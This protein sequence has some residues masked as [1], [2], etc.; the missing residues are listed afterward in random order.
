LITAS[1]VGGGFFLYHVRTVIIGLVLF[2]A[3]LAL[4][5][6]SGNRHVRGRL[7]GS[8]LAFA[9]YALAHSLLNYADLTA[10]FRQQI[11]TFAPL[12]LAW[13]VISGIVAIV[14]NP[15][16]GDRTPDRFP[17][18]VQ[19]ALA[20]ALFAIAATI[21]LQ[22]KIVA[23]TAVSA[24]VI[25]FA[26]QDTLGNLFAGLA[27]Q[28]EKPFRVGHWVHI[29][30]KDGMVHEITWRA[31]KIRT[32]AGN[33]VIVPNS[34]L[35]KEPITNYS[36]PFLPT[37][38][39]VEVGASYNDPP[40]E[41]QA[42]I[43]EALEHEP[44]IARQPQP[45]V[46][47][48]NFADSAITYRAR[49]WI[50]DYAADERTTTRVRLLI[51]HTFRRRGF[52]IPYP[53]AWRLERGDDPHT[54][55]I[56]ETAAAQALDAVEIFAA[57]NVEDREQLR[58]S[59]APVHY[60][61][62][63]TI[64]RQGEAGTSMFVVVTG[65]AKVTLEPSGQEVFRFHGQGFFGEM[66][67]LTGEPR[68][69]TVTAVTACDLL[70]ITADAFRRFVLAR[71]ASVEAIGMATAQRAT[72]LTRLRNAGAASDRPV[73]PPASLVSRIRRFLRI[74]SIILVTS[75]A[76]AASPAS[77]GE[78]GLQITNDGR[79]TVVAV[80]SKT[81][82]TLDGALDEP[83]WTAAEP[84]GGFVQAE[85][86]EGQPAT[87]TTEVRLV[88]DS[89]ALYLGVRCNDA[90]G[91]RTIIN[92]IRKDFSAGEQDSFEVI[93][94]TFADRRNGFVFVVN[95]VGGKSDTQIAN[96]GRDV[97][98]SWDAVWFVVTRVD[99]TGW[100]AEIRIPFKTLRFEPGVDRV[101][102]VNFS[103]RI[104]R[105]N[106]VDFW[107]PVPRV[108]NLYRASLGGTMSG[109]PNANPGRNLRLKPWVSGDATRAVSGKEFDND[110]HAGIDLKY[111]VTPSL[112]L[113]VTAR[114][115]FAQAEADEQQ[116]NLTQF[117]LFYPEKREFFLENSGM[118]YFGDIPRESRL[119][120]ARFA[121]PEEEILLFFSRRI[122]LTNTGDPIPIAAGGRLTGRVGRTGLGLMTIQT[123]SDDGRD[124]DNYTVLRG[125]R[126][127]LRN[128]DIGGIFLSRQ[129]TGDGGRNQVAG[130]DANFR[131]INALSLNGFL[132]QS[133]TPGKSS[134]QVA[135]K[136]AITWN[137]NTLHTQYSLLSI[138]DNFRD[139]IGFIKR[140]GIRKHFVDF[141]IR[142]RP[143]WWR[144]YGIRELHPHTRYNIYTDQS[145]QKVS[146]T[147]HVA[148][149]T[150]FERGGYLEAQWNPRFER[151]TTPFR[152][153]PD[154]SFPVGSYSWNEFAVELET[155][156]S[157]K[158]SGSALVTGG[159]FWSGTQRSAKL[160]VVYRPSYHLT[161]DTALQRNDISLPAPMHDFT[162]NLIASR[163]GYAF[164]TRT[165]LDTLLQYNTDLKQ[166]SA[167]VRF[168]LIHRPLSDLFIVY[169]EQQLTDSPVPVSSGRGLIVKYTHMVAF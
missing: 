113:D 101:W 105:K 93:L 41:V 88:F 36:E 35:S 63:E 25:G 46:V 62:G 84:A 117:S 114:P 166:F 153:R 4:R 11:V 160:G 131:F 47:I 165:F 91:G 80:E 43:L 39:E 96:E 28:I 94:D 58:R 61:E 167:N 103:R 115:D 138:G 45:D 70:E 54:R 74:G 17:N 50:D 16:R 33:L 157:Q 168:D 73:E 107:S 72:E 169:N 29:A 98:A 10:D 20:I 44:M 104:R 40:D 106:E 24:V 52:T 8:A 164:N 139:D 137:A 155:D 132:A 144:K 89:E 59:A 6:V 48:V 152:V 7:F 37:R 42:A 82:I 78:R 60:L 34:M 86:H 19:D 148:M 90:S 55:P 111:G 130:V 68:T 85:P 136:G 75:G 71:P 123:Q 140:S 127:V 135:G 116:V 158:L 67:L 18:I 97:N 143:E 126:D 15:W 125:R 3:A 31:T 112:T 161:F 21:V 1:A 23:T 79:R 66:S 145:N 49:V 150:F 151:I 133:F 110:A 30:G 56:D 65:D 163:V 162:T 57:L 120:N 76:A 22:E 64:V 159:G 99:G 69:A 32:K 121:P 14:A 87:E 81:P 146:H 108:Y 92:D 27:I 51:Y 141:G 77:A 128:G 26:L 154:Q 124:G 149:A 2:A 134:G 13:G 12:L 83:V 102:G 129:S 119:G 122:G 95:P 38:L 5:S 100:T 156:H 147:N 142:K 118:F 109:L 9:A 53:I